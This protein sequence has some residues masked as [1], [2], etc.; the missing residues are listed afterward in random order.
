VLMRV[1]LTRAHCFFCV[2][3]LMQCV[4]IAFAV[5]MTLA[6]AGTRPLFPDILE[7]I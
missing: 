3:V 7:A 2:Y 4:R 5:L 1:P 6:A